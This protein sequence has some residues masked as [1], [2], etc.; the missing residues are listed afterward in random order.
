M[1]TAI[2]QFIIQF[3]SQDWLRKML[4]EKIRPFVANFE[5]I[6]PELLD[7]IKFADSLTG[8]DNPTKRKEAGKHLLEKLQSKKIDI[9]GE[10][11][12]EVC[13]LLVEGMYQGLKAIRPSSAK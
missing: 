8:A 10:V 5:K 11:D 2:I 9:P 13:E 3:I 1:I 12:L 4:P 6:A 7:A